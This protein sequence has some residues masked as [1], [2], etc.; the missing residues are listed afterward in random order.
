MSMPENDRLFGKAN[1]GE[2]A[3]RLTV[4]FLFE[5]RTVVAHEGETVAAAL[6]ASGVGHF[7]T[8]PVSAQRARRIA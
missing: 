8:T 6:L 5:G 1:F 7:R 4:S 2:I 3:Q